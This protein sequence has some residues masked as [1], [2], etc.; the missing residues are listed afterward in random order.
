M[1]NDYHKVDRSSERRVSLV[2]V[3]NDQSVDSL[4]DSATRP[5]SRMKRSALD[6]VDIMMNQPDS[7]NAK[8]SEEYLQ[9]ST[10][11]RP[12]P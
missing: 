7:T 5:S 10:H 8:I 11:A 12:F 6:A 1:A 3:L 2:I 9:Y 4:Y